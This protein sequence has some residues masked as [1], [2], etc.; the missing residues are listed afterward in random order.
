MLFRLT[1]LRELFLLVVLQWCFHLRLPSSSPNAMI[2]SSLPSLLMMKVTL[3][4]TIIHTAIWWFTHQMYLIILFILCRQQIQQSR[5]LPIS[6]TMNYLPVPIIHVI[7][8]Q[9]N[10]P[11][12]RVFSSTSRST[13]NNTCPILTPYYIWLSED[14]LLFGW[15]KTRNQRFLAKAANA[16]LIHTGALTPT[17]GSFS[18]IPNPPCGKALHKRRLISG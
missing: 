6:P 8:G 9:P 5:M 4:L 2:M 1:S 14:L 7:S 11:P 16:A 18:T 10:I 17:L 13:F 3:F 15:R 12:S